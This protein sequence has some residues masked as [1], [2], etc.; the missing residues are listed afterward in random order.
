[1]RKRSRLLNLSSHRTR[2]CS[3]VE[4]NTWL[5]TIWLLSH[6]PPASGRRASRGVRRE[7]D[8]VQTL[9]SCSTQDSRP[10]TLTGQHRR[11]DSGGLGRG[12]PA[13]REWEQESWP[14]S[15]LVAARGE[16]IRTVLE[17]EQC[18]D[19]SATTQ[20]SIQGSE[21]AHPISTPSLW[22][23]GASERAR[24]ADPKLQDLHDTGQAQAI[25]EESH[26]GSS[27]DDVAEARDLKT[28]QWLIAAN[29]CK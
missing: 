28:G 15:L 6:P 14:C 26:W 10:H 23:A 19:N 13:P 16:L 18:A 20:A 4:G 27:V 3:I 1:M 12:D 17:Q 7:G 25:W 9:V 11:A 21:L 2:N 8:L 24:P 29:I 5:E 22:T